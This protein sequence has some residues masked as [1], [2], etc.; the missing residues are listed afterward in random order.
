MYIIMWKYEVRT[1]HI[2]D[3][4]EI[5]SPNGLWAELF[6]Q[7]PGYISTELL[8]D[9]TNSSRYIT[10][11]RWESAESYEVFQSQFRNE[12]ETLDAQCERLTEHEILLGMWESTSNETR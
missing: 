9:K 10:I 7:A 6:R 8:R 5:Y 11:D 3:F 12:Y 2:H 1:N 4:E